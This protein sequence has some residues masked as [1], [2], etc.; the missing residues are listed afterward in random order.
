M[1]YNSL[2]SFIQ[3]YIKQNGNEEITGPVLQNVLL[4]MVSLLGKDFQFAGIANPSTSPGTP[5]EQV[6]YIG[7]AG[8]YNNFGS[9]VVEVPIGS[10][11]IFYY[12]S[13]WHSSIVR[14]DSNDL[15][16]IN[17]Y[18]GRTTGY[19]DAV[20]ARNQVPADLRKLGMQITYLSGGAWHTEQYIGSVADLTS[21]NWSDNSNWSTI[22]SNGE[23]GTDQLANNAV[24]TN[25]INDGA[26]TSGKIADSAVTSAKINDGAVGTSKLGSKSVTNAKIDDNTISIDKIASSAFDSQPTED[27]NKL[28][29]SG[30][31]Y[32]AIR[33]LLTTG[34]T[35]VGIA[36]TSTTPGTPTQNVFFI[37]GAGSYSSTNW[38]SNVDVPQGSMVIFYYDSE[39][40]SAVLRTASDHYLNVNIYRNE[41]TQT[42]TALVARGH[43]PADL[44][45][46]GI[47]ITYLT[48][49]G[50]I[51]EL[52]IDN[53]G[54]WTA[55]AN[56]Q[57]L[58]PVS[59]SQNIETGKTELLIGDTPALIVD[60]NV[61]E[62]SDNLIKNNGVFA[63]ANKPMMAEILTSKYF[64][65]DIS[66]PDVGFLYEKYLTYATNPILGS[67]PNAKTTNPIQ[68]LAGQTILF[69]TAGSGICFLATTDVSATQ[70]TLVIGS[71]FPS[72]G[73]IQ[74]KATQDCY[75]AL[76][77]VY[78][79]QD[80][81]C[82][83]YAIISGEGV[84]EDC[85]FSKKQLEFLIPTNIY[86]YSSQ[87]V[88]NA[89][90]SLTGVTSRQFRLLNYTGTQKVIKVPLVAGKYY[91]IPFHD[92]FPYNFLVTDFDYEGTTSSK[93]TPTI[94]G[95]KE[96]V[97]VDYVK[98]PLVQTIGNYCTFKITEE[99][100]F[101]YV[102]IGGGSFESYDYSGDYQILESDN[103]IGL[104]SIIDNIENRLSALEQGA[105]YI[106]ADKVI[107]VFGDSITWLGGDDCDGTRSGY[108]HKGWT[109]YFK[110]A[111]N[112]LLMKSFA[113]SGATLSCFTTSS[114]DASAY[115]G[116]PDKDNIV[117]NQ[118]IR[119]K[120]HIQ[121]GGAIPDFILIAAGI[122]D[123]MIFES[124]SSTYA[125]L[126]D[127]IQGLLSDNVED[128]LNANVSTS[129]FGSKTPSQCA[130]I[131]KTLRWIKDACISI[132]PNAQIILLTPLQGGLC[133]LSLQNQ[134]TQR[135][136]DCSAYMSASHINQGKECGISQ[137][138]ESKGYH[139]T[140]DGTHTSVIG[141]TRVG[142]ILATRFK[143]FAF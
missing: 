51:T 80:D 10:L 97:L 124:T 95:Y 129:W 30:T 49:N 29:F 89:L 130:S 21:A 78:K 79:G 119:M 135:I 46:K 53:S 90:V 15:F 22:L 134:I 73:M 34:Y 141:A 57:V 83:D 132:C 131:A 39:W 71:T 139:F 91:A 98:S 32:N 112:P 48:A 114:E 110:N 56:W 13:S 109:E 4:Q 136:I 76:S 2:K 81:A 40:H 59:V 92:I 123:G 99:N 142:K 70:Y 61:E 6:F 37:A 27:S 11:V 113:R 84:K 96:Q 75:V 38:G 23:V 106:F 28:L 31:I 107:Y 19:G 41:P 50:W 118:I 18:K 65:Y 67:H 20:V 62:Q 82:F 120:N 43:V 100:Q 35:F 105:E 94:Y 55:D 122:N 115:Y 60:N 72:S 117:W 87:S 24:T 86:D 12:D 44:R 1:G 77:G 42:Y 140:Y 104:S 138:Q 128:E 85:D 26:V 125:E 63:F 3:N 116:S 126:H 36:N 74:Y 133:S 8:S 5:D 25:K 14:T 33:T 111:I 54:T 47:I 17:S 127:A 9:S 121:N 45:K 93:L 137:L 68:L 103:M 66:V 88:D 108:E 69:K 101:L 58:G 64:G 143:A 52:C 16:N 7:A 102:N